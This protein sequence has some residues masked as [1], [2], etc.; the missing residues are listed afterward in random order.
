MQTVIDVL[1]STGWMV[2]QPAVA[3]AC[4]TAAAK[5][6][7]LVGSHRAAA[8]VTAAASAVAPPSAHEQHT[9]TVRLDSELPV[10]LC[11]LILAHILMTFWQLASC[12]FNYLQLLGQ[13]LE[14]QS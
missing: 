13:M 12:V 7:D 9:S 3:M 5:V 6:E 11:C 10:D 2:G 4:A 1:A 14:P 8:A